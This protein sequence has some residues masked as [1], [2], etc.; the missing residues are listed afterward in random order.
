MRMNHLISHNGDH[1]WPPRS[2]DLT[3]CD[4]FLWDSHKSLVYVNKPWNIHD[5]KEEIRQVV[6]QSLASFRDR[7]LACQRC[8]GTHMPDIVLRTWNGRVNWTCLC[9]ILMCFKNK[10]HILNVSKPA[11][12]LKEPL[13]HQVKDYF[14]IEDF[15]NHTPCH[16]LYG[17][18]INSTK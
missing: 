15:G 4:L 6:R 12:F 18:K 2:C 11:R 9:P 10:V 13:L 7:V 3:P 8:R 16:R 17:G 14:I 1:Q 5:L